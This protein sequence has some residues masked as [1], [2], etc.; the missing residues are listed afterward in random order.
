MKA[1]VTALQLAGVGASIWGKEGPH[2]ERLE[3]ERPVWILWEYL[4]MRC[5]SSRNGM[6]GKH[7]LKKQ[8]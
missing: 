2:G 8:N 4:E 3:A 7:T 1:K 6:A 5:G